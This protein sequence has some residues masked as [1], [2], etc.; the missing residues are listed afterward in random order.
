MLAGAEP[1]QEQVGGSGAVW[2]LRL[3]PACAG[4]LVGPAR[5]E[6]A[7]PFSESG[8]ARWPCMANP[9]AFAPWGPGGAGGVPE[10]GRLGL[11][12]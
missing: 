9:G 2:G 4:D 1:A 5:R 3:R 12:T 8:G 10:G 7:P 11:T 6:P